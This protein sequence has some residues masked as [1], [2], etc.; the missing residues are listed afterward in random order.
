MLSNTPTSRSFSL[1]CLPRRVRVFGAAWLVAG[2]AGSAGAATPAESG[3]NPTIELAADEA[4]QRDDVEAELSRRGGHSA[5]AAA[6]QQ[7]LD[8]LVGRRLRATAAIDTGYAEDPEIRDA[9]ERLLAARFERDHLQPLLA[10]I[11]VTDD[12]VVARYAE[13]PE[14]FATAEQVRVAVIRL[15]GPTQPG[16]ADEIEAAVAAVDPE[17]GFGDLARRHSADRASRYVGGVLGWW[18]HGDS[19]RRPDAVVELGFA[20]RTVG[21]VGRV[22]AE[23]DTYLMRL[24]ERR[25]ASP[26][27]FDKVASTIRRQLMMERRAAVRDAFH[28]E[29]RERYPV[30]VDPLAREPSTRSR[31]LT[32]PSLPADPATRNPGPSRN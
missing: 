28:A 9:I 22:E 15:D 20:L 30:E 3:S 14:R 16:L 32:P 19:S 17:R 21:E 25:A 1:P 5:G 23:G 13:A 4:I 2:L 29:L 27:A 26:R 11:E 18:T 7:T 10:A 8:D 24:V 6:W 12:E 31:A